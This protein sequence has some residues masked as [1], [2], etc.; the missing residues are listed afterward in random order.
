MLFGKSK[1]ILFIVI[2]CFT[3]VLLEAAEFGIKMGTGY[4]NLENG[5]YYK[6]EFNGLRES[7]YYE[8]F[9]DSAGQE[10]IIDTAFIK[11]ML[12]T[13]TEAEIENKMTFSGGFYARFNLHKNVNNK[14]KS[15]NGINLLLETN[16][17]HHK[18]TFKFGNSINNSIVTSPDVTQ[19]MIN[20]GQISNTEA[21]NIISGVNSNPTSDLS[22]DYVEIPL[23]LELMKKYEKTESPYHSAYIYFGP[24]LRVC[25]NSV[26]EI[27]KDLKRILPLYE[28]GLNFNYEAS[29]DTV[30]VIEDYRKIETSRTE[31]ADSFNEVTKSIT[32]GCGI[33]LDKIFNLDLGSDTFSFDFRANIGWGKINDF[34]SKDFTLNSYNFLL[35]YKF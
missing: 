22:L 15:Y 13:T 7:Q 30:T 16:Y 3:T 31:I 14:E 17:Q 35:G 32:V 12:T 26:E 6:M 29:S 19:T 33:Q 10:T 23:M 20:S 8:A 21:T 2:L 5:K 25:L 1:I 18:V 27:S 34:S 4:S 28:E 11:M 24:A 9:Y